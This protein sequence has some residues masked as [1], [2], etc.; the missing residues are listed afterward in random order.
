MY[1][2]DISPYINMADPLKANK[3]AGFVASVPLA[4]HLE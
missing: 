1:R 4:T 3:Q 2:V